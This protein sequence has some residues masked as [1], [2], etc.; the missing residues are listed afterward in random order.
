MKVTK[1]IDSSVS[2]L[3]RCWTSSHTTA[4]EGRPGAARSASTAASEIVVSTCSMA[5][6][7]T[8][9]MSSSL[10]SARIT[11]ASSLATSQRITS[12]SGL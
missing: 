12:P 3:V 8:R 5:M 6:E 7:P 11:L 4:S 9:G 1:L 2:S 10:R